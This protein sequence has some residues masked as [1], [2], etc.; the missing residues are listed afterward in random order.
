MASDYTATYTALANFSQL[1]REAK[2]A[3]SDLKDLRKQ[4]AELNAQSMASAPK[5]NQF[6]EALAKAANVSKTHRD[7]TRNLTTAQTALAS[8]T[9][10]AEQAFNNAKK[11]QADY[12][13]V[14]RDSHASTSQVTSAHTAL[15]RALLESENASRRLERAVKDVDSAHTKAT[16]SVHLFHNAMSKIGENQGPIAH[17]VNLT[18]K[19]EMLG[20]KFLAMGSLVSPAVAA[21]SDFGGAAIALV[22]TLGP[23]AGSLAALPQ[24]F[25]AV[26]Q[27]AATAFLGFGGVMK[28]VGALNTAVVQAGANTQATA[29]QQMLAA[30]AVSDASRGIRDASEAAAT[31]ARDTANQ[32]QAANIQVR[33]S[34]EALQMAERGLID[35]RREQTRALE[36]L[37]TAVKREALAERSAS[38]SVAEARANLQRAMLDPNATAFQREEATVAFQEAENRQQDV[39]TT[40]TRQNQDLR[41]EQQR[42]GVEG[43]NAV[44]DARRSLRDANEA[45]SLSE[46]DLANTIRDGAIANRNAREAETRA[47]LAY[48]DALYAQKH[49][50]DAVGDS[51]QNLKKI[52]A[53][54]GPAQIQ[55]AKDIFA[56]KGKF[57]ELQDAAAKGLLPGVETAI[58]NM[59]PVW[60]VLNGIITKTAGA[61]GD[62]IGK[63][64]AHFTTPKWLEFL[65]KL[66]DSNIKVLNSLSDAFLS[67]ADAFRDIM[68]AAM[69]F[70]EWFAG[71]IDTLAKKAASWTHGH[72]KELAHFFGPG[73]A[74]RTALHGWGGVLGN[75]GS[76]LINTFKAAMP[77]G[78]QLLGMLDRLTSKWATALKPP[79]KP[80]LPKGANAAERQDY[81]DQM[82]DNE[83]SPL[84]KFTN[85]LEGSLPTLQAAGHLIG[86]IADSW[87]QLTTSGQQSSPK[88]INALAD[89][90]IP[91]L[92]KLLTT[93]G[94]NAPKLI[95]FFTQLTEALG[96]LLS[97]ESGGT[98]KVALNIL[99]NLATLLNKLLDMKG[100][101]G[102]VKDLFL[103]A[104]ALKA[105]S[106][107]GKFTGISGAIGSVISAPGRVRAARQ[108]Y[109]AGQAGEEFG[110]SY[111]VDITERQQSSYRRGRVAGRGSRWFGGRGGGGASA[112]QEELPFATGDEQ[113][114]LFDS[115]A[116]QPKTRGRFRQWFADRSLRSP[117]RGGAGFSGGGAE[118]GGEGGFV[119]AGRATADSGGRWTRNRWTDGRSAPLHM[120]ASRLATPGVSDDYDTMYAS[121]MGGITPPAED[122]QTWAPSGRRSLRERVRGHFAR[123]GGR[124]KSVAKAIPSLTIAGVS[125]LTGAPV[126]I[127][128][129]SYEATEKVREARQE[130]LKESGVAPRTRRFGGVAATGASIAG[131]VLLQHYGEG[132]AEKISGDPHAI[133]KAQK[134]FDSTGKELTEAQKAASEA[135]KKHADAVTAVEKAQEAAAEAQAE[136]QKHLMDGTE[137]TK[138][139]KVAAGKVVT[140]QKRLNAAM[141]TEAKTADAAA[142]TSDKLDEATANH[143]AAGQELQAAKKEGNGG[144]LGHQVNSTA[145]SL[146][147]GVF[148]LA[149]P[150]IA[151]T[152]A[153]KTF[154]GLFSGRENDAGDA[155][156]SRAGS[157]LSKVGGGIKN[158]LR[159]ALGFGD[160]AKGAVE[161]LEGDAK[162]A[163][164]GKAE[165]AAQGVLGKAAGKV[166]EGAAKIAGHTKELASKVAGHGKELA[167]KFSEHAGNMVT[168]VAG[169]MGNLV[170]KVGGA[171]SKIGTLLMANPWIIL[172]VALAIVVY[173]VIKHWD[174][175]KHAVEV[176]IDWVWGFIKK[177]WPL[178]LTILMG[179]FGLFLAFL[180]KHFD[181]VKQ[182]FNDVIGGIWKILKG[183]WALI[184]DLF[185]APIRVIKDLLTGDFGDIK[186]VFSGLVRDL[187]AIWG[188][189]KQVFE[190]PVKFLIN[191]VIEDGIIKNVNKVLD[192]LPGN[193]HIP[194]IS[195]GGG[196]GA[197]VA[198]TKSARSIKAARG[199]LVPGYGNTDSVD[200]DLMPGEF[201]IR[202]AAVKRIG[203]GNLARMNDQHFHAGGPV[204]VI[205]GALSGAAGIAK[206]AWDAGKGLV[207]L[208]KDGAQWLAVKGIHGIRDAANATIDKIPGMK[209]LLAS[210]AH[211]TNNKIFG[212]LEAA[213]HG[214]GQA[215]GNRSTAHAPGNLTGNTVLGKSMA[216]STFGWTGPQWDALYAL[217]QQ[218]SGWN[219]F[220]GNP[221]HAY[222][223]P[224]SLPGSKMAAFGSDWASNPATQIAWGLDYIHRQYKN[225]AAAWA[226]KA[227]TDSRKGATGQY[228]QPGGWYANGGL[229]KAKVT[230]GEFVMNKDAVSKYGTSAM[231]RLNHADQF[232]A[233]GGFVSPPPIFAGTTVRPMSARSASTST[234][235][236]QGPLIGE[237]VNNWAPEVSTDEALDKTMK[238]LAYLGVF[239]DD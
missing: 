116:G 219:E 56:L 159:K 117:S 187:G 15:R 88:I 71:G 134:E 143:D 121:L 141:E 65:T 138:A 68:A 214:G 41:T 177:R 234:P 33:N 148:G 17:I 111:P 34:H 104:A 52:F 200:A 19:L 136:Y 202:K 6:S 53:G 91:A 5:I 58:R 49:A 13:K 99:D 35:T 89:E 132:F 20:A 38:L 140:T 209:G 119:M 27:G 146:G 168:K 144:I 60:G 184:S 232:F 77:F 93:L 63:A 73:G 43:T 50:L 211:G 39:R 225:P 193:L 199:G 113:L 205:E 221:A 32:I 217:W 87:A 21:L 114:G 85:F 100:I 14:T 142:E 197:S 239:G 83:D 163:V 105:I 12:D 183:S 188:G 172:V 109:R 164:E 195:W 18:A 182:L 218:E 166:K 126:D 80:V 175:I 8:A 102:L 206:G 125:S 196:G 118:F 133:E 26:G 11:A 46:R 165:D 69:P 108:G 139:G 98:F 51:A 57:E 161:S 1:K 180:I 226:H 145:V 84:V 156:K 151:G 210:L 198:S 237:V 103:L 131:A 174:A 54:M 238:K 3:E 42:G 124:Y 220:A 40:N 190:A 101:G 223:I 216:A 173:E 30:R 45:V 31:T 28:A 78:L 212:G 178:I 222:G 76:I 208:A 44:I 16:S 107:V 149:A 127:A 22:G 235:V 137:N 204:G 110:A 213:I 4:Q 170:G 79:K 128:A 24:L 112:T 227:A 191:T 36:D 215:T 228:A 153:M 169:H 152:V 157:A 72:G 81:F 230:P 224:Q 135:N 201:V 122:E 129:G 171:L 48:N 25:S 233:G 106:L 192:K 59:A 155:V 92:V 158:T 181:A 10:S 95:D 75:V 96:K 130:A 29:H 94:D 150:Q 167:G 207:S 123:Q 82:K 37:E 64:S 67:I 90:L 55:M 236:H 97:G 70:V 160:E 231:H 120:E 229:V 179:P 23:L 185:M 62:F 186:D 2:Q 154:H 86:V 66:G 147:M 74:L 189:I 194:D 176:A 115:P 61:F 7:A 47:G 203:V 9:L 162:D